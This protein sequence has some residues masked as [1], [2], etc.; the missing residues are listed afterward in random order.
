MSEALHNAEQ[1]F[2][3]PPAQ[4]QPVRTQ[5]ETCARCGAEFV[6]GARYCHVCGGEREPLLDYSGGTFSRWLDFHQIR[7][8]LG[9]STGA[10]VAF[11]FGVGCV[12][13]AILTGFLFT[14]STVLDWQA[15][16]VWRIEW[17]LGGVAAFLAGL[18]LNKRSA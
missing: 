16:Q 18:L 11:I 6:L 8:A 1:E 10:L 14:A 7:T 15:V 13:A 5:V 12:V 2:W 3:R 17:L 4:T 9:L